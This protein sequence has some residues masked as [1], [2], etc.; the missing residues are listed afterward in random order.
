MFK[1][2]VDFLRQHIDVLVLKDETGN[3]QVAVSPEL[4]GRVLTST[5]AGDKGLSF[6]WINHDFIAS[7]EKNRHFNPYGGE[8]RFWLGPEGG[9]F[10]IF[11]EKGAEFTL[12]D[13]YT[14]EPINDG[15]YDV[16]TEEDDKVVFNTKMY[17]ENYSGYEFDLELTREIALLSKTEVLNLLG[18]SETDVPMVAFQSKNKVKN[19]G[20]GEWNK[21]TGM[22]SIWILG[23]FN[24][25]PATT[26]VIPFK[27]GPKEELGPI[28]NDAYFGKVPSDRL[29]VK[30]DVL[31]FKGDGKY[32]SKIGISPR[33]AKPLM[34]S[35]DAD[36]KVLTLVH[37]T[38][39]D[40]ATDYVNSMWEIQERPFSGDAANSYNDG[41]PEPGADP[42]GPFYELESS[43]PALK[44][45]PEETMTHKHT[46]MHF[47]GDKEELDKI[48]RATLG[49]SLKDI[50]AAFK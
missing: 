36:N 40:G 22:L 1:Q 5:A 47:Q 30:E 38:L 23:M 50:T 21:R 49:V 32:R 17:V 10:S 26:V 18:L 3:A 11:F 24:P 39:P 43:S 2:D 16:I 34:G 45:K 29:V 7:G 48:A 15:A 4:Q 42:L 37:F 46:T 28:V 41:P 8:D 33:R 27:S 20:E 31:F 35:Y 14:P 6:G 12:D 19:I 9:Q 25:S 13:W 44:L